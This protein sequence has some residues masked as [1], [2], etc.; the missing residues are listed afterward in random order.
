MTNEP[1]EPRSTETVVSE[2]RDANP[3]LTA[4]RPRS[5]VGISM[6]IG[7]FI[8]FLIG[9]THSR[10]FALTMF[11]GAAFGGAVGAVIDERRRRNGRVN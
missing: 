9:V 1:T 8:G 4:P 5:V 7:L 10:L 3:Q 2:K 11:F 6:G